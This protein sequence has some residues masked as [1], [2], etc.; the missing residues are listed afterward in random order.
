MDKPIKSAKDIVAELDKFVI[1]HEHAKKLLATTMTT[2]DL[3]FRFNKKSN[4][5][6]LK[7]LNL[8]LI[9]AS[10]TGKTYLLT[11]IA[12]LFN[13]R[14]HHVDATNYSQRGYVGGSVN[15][16]AQ[17]IVQASVTTDRPLIVFLDE[18]DKLGS[19]H[20][21][22]HGVSTT[23]VQHEFLKLTESDEFNS[24]I[25]WVFA[26][27]FNDAMTKYNKTKFKIGF[28]QDTEEEKIKVID[29]SFLLEA[30]LIPEL[31]GR[32]GCITAL[33][34]LTEELLMEILVNGSESPLFQ[35]KVI[36]SIKGIDL[37]LTEEELTAIVRDVQKK[38]L[39]ARPLFE[40][41]HRLFLDKLYI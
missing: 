22:S 41:V 32:M 5:I 14:V 40:H 24:N 35:Y 16:L 34:D 18:V 13:Y 17:E 11:T 23:S 26:G 6:K 27:A 7:P 10:G 29:Q 20:D 25:M 21:S 30:G 37:S 33:S 4:K 15:D 3:I 12:K 8:T 31:I 39:G 1:G 2:N 36:G 38:K 9:G 28:N 19:I